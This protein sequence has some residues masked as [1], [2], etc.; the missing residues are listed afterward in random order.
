MRLSKICLL[1]IF[2]TTEGELSW[3]T[4]YARLSAVGKKAFFVPRKERVLSLL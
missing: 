2:Q 1:E 3:Y 4:G